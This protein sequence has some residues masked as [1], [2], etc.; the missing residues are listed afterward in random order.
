MRRA[1][2]DATP[3]RQSFQASGGRPDDARSWLI[4]LS[5]PV[6][7]IIWISAVGAGAGAGG[8]GATAPAV[9]LAPAVGA[10]AA[11]GAGEA[12]AGEAAAGDCLAGWAPGTWRAPAA[13]GAS[14]ALNHG[15]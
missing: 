12:G 9:G 7:A 14:S 5:W 10:A 13:A 8:R 4:R 2:A 11:A 6:A 3:A 15:G 1:S